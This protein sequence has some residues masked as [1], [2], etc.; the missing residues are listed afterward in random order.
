MLKQKLS[1]QVQIWFDDSCTLSGNQSSA[2]HP[3][4]ILSSKPWLRW[5]H[6]VECAVCCDILGDN[7][8]YALA[9]DTLTGH[10]KHNYYHFASVKTVLNKPVTITLCIRILSCDVDVEFTS[11]QAMN[12]A[13]LCLDSHE[14]CS[15][16]TNIQSALYVVVPARQMGWPPNDLW[17]STFREAGPWIVSSGLH[18]S[19]MYCQNGCR[20]FEPTWARCCLRG[21][22]MTSA[23]IPTD[24]GYTRN[25]RLDT[26]N[27][28]GCWKQQRISSI[29]P[30]G[31]DNSIKGTLFLNCFKF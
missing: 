26:A 1:F 18:H 4:G 25:F 17:H 29:V 11:E 24:L 15:S 13:C 22:H 21:D 2:L 28:F 9:F 10:R 3:M 5:T 30:V 12:T 7:E 16:I 14:T 23:G 8:A 20:T 19:Q 31:I 6:C 27:S